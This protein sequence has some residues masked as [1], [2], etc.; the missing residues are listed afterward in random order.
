MAKS[1]ANSVF[2]NCPFD[3]EFAPGFQALIFA[4]IRCGFQVRC[5]REMADGAETRIDKLYNIIEQCR[6]SIHDL[7]RT[8]LDAVNH[9]PR[10][11]MPLELGVFL[12]AKRYGDDQQKKKRCAIMDVDQYRYQKFISDLNG[13][14]IQAHGGVTR[15]MVEHVRTFLLTGS[16]RKTIPDLVELLDS[17]DR[18]VVALP[19]LA[20]PHNPNPLKVIYPDFERLVINWTQA[21]L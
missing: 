16:G 10:F 21:G 3:D 11:N 12:G 2:I 7:S 15:Q 17:Y 20:A 5:A 8:E 19:A 9:L 6:Y 18:F 4:V 14:D 1:P 13:M